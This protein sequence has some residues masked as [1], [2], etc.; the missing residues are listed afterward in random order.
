MEIRALRNLAA[1][2]VKCEE[3]DRLLWEL[4][5]AGVGLREIEEFVG[6]EH[7][8]LRDSNRNC[9]RGSKDAKMRSEIVTSLMEMKRRDNKKEGDNLRKKR[10]KMRRTIEDKLGQNSRCYRW[11][12]RTIK[13]NGKVL[14][15]KLRKKNL[16]KVEFLMKKYKKSEDPL[17]ELT[18]DDRTKYGGARIFNDD[19]MMRRMDDDKPVIVLRENEVITL[20]KDEES[21]L[22]LGPKFCVLNNLNDEEFERELEESIVKLRWELMSEEL[23]LKEKKKFGEEAWDN[24][25]LFYTEEELRLEKIEKQLDEAK[26]RQIY[27]DEERSLNF[28]KRRVSDI[29]GNARVILPKRMR[30]FE[31]ETRLETLRVECRGVFSEYMAKNCN[32]YGAQ[33]SNLTKGELKGLKS[34]KKRI[35]EGEIVIIPTDKTSN[36]AVLTRATY[37]AA[38]LKHTKNDIEVGWPELEE[39]QKEINGHVSMAI[40]VFNMGENWGHMDRIRETML[41]GGAY[42]VPCN[43]L[44][45]RSQG[46]GQQ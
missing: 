20:S 8:K 46:V 19:S 32:K 41:G 33:R 11:V 43:T 7:R 6:R 18:S 39:S 2:I 9:S 21:V 5:K 45:Q 24:L 22:A 34:L 36:F 12:I 44:V 40:K 17:D 29:K 13:I 1:K 4:T 30:D 15:D 14:R 42:C 27:D 35:S 23:E 31:L 3:R 25:N 37:E 26:M 28:A 16:K 10:N 38:G